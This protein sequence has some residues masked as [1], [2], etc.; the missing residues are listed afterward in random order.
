MDCI[1]I[2]AFQIIALVRRFQHLFGTQIL[3]MI[4]INYD[5]SAKI[6]TIIKI[7]FPTKDA[8]ASSNK[9]EVNIFIFLSKGSD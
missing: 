3:M 4:M 5:L 7:C 1:K 2:S 9:F 6:I 8:A